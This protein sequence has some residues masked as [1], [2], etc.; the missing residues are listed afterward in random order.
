MGLLSNLPQGQTVQCS[1]KVHSRVTSPT[2]PAQL[3]VAN[4]SCEI[5]KLFRVVGLFGMV[6]RRKPLF[7]KKTMLALLKFI[8]VHPSKPQDFRRNVLW[9]DQ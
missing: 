8:K 6:T 7:S 1:E 9:R 4:L 3:G 2:L 5:L